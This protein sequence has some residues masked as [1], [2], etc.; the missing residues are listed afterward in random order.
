[1][2]TVAGNMTMF[3][4][5]DL[6][7]NYINKDNPYLKYGGLLVIVALVVVLERRYRTL[8]NRYASARIAE[9]A[10]AERTPEAAERTTLASN[11]AAP[12]QRAARHQAEYPERSRNEFASAEEA[13]T[14][15]I[16]AGERVGSRPH[17]S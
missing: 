1:M 8:K 6:L 14:L 7:G 2:G 4:F 9:A 15:E 12:T 3:M 10:L 5:S 11:A 17:S 16:A 13:G